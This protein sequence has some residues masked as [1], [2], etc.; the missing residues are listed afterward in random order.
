MTTE[1]YRA[2]QTA[3]SRPS[4]RTPALMERRKQAT[5]LWRVIIAKKEKVRITNRIL[6]NCKSDKAIEKWTKIITE[7]IT[8]LNIAKENF[9]NF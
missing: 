4:S 8:E 1:Q 9:K 5:I 3:C 7:K 2:L 6:E